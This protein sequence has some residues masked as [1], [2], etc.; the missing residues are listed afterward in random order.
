MVRST[1]TYVVLPVSRETYDEIFHA[2]QEACYDHAIHNDNGRVVI[3][4]HG[5]ALARKDLS[6]G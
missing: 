2:L 5:I 1:Y 4:M 6:D 3:D